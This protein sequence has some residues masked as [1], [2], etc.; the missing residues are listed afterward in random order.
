V[1]I[2]AIAFDPYTAAT[3]TAVANTNV[4]TS[5]VAAT[6]AATITVPATVPA[7]ADI[8]EGIRYIYFG[9]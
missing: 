7:V 8:K 1:A 2:N 6:S 9:V 5:I 3:S 4:A